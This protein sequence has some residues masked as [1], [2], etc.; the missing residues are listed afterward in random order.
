MNNAYYADRFILNLLVGG[1]VACLVVANFDFL[2]A[3]IPS[4]HR[5]TP[6]IALVLA[7]SVVVC[8]LFVVPFLYGRFR[9]ARPIFE[10]RDSIRAAWLGRLVGMGIGIVAGIGIEG[11]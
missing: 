8:L 7:I 10:D 5:A 6:R 4:L 1:F 3:F 11:T 9:P 2:T